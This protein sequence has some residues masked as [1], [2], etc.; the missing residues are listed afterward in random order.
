MQKIEKFWCSSEAIFEKVQFWTIFD[1]LTLTTVGQEFFRKLKNITFLYLCCSNFAQNIKNFW[2]ADPEISPLRTT[3]RTDG[4]TDDRTD[5]AEFIGPFRLKQWVQKVK[6]N[7]K[8]QRK[9]LKNILVRA[10]VP[11]LKTKDSFRGPCNKPRC[12]I[13]KHITKTH[14][15]VSFSTKRIYS[16]RSQNLNCALM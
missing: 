7:V 4:R 11:S 12:K 14:E 16:I 2:H 9:N 6:V 8:L 10:K 5:E 1:L 3:Q 15:L 13:C